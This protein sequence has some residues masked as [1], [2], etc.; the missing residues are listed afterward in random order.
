MNEEYYHTKGSVEE[1]IKM[2]KGID[3][4]LLIEKMKSFTKNG[5]KLLELGTG[6]GSDYLLLQQTYE[7]TGSDYSEVFLSHL[8][9]TYPEG[10]FISIDATTI[11]TAQS[12][13]VIYSNKVLHHLRQEQLLSSI[14]RQASILLPDGIICHSFWK[15]E[16]AESFNGTWVQYYDKNEL[17]KLFSKYFEILLLETYDEFDH[18]D[19]LLLIAKKR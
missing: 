1:Y 19:S 6:P 14:E 10:K 2:A 12:Y 17:T 5:R 18:D 11:D 3:G 8:R 13:Q 4:A 15:G 16:G 9:K 7:V